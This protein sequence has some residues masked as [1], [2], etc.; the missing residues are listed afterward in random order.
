MAAVDELTELV[1]RAAAEKPALAS[2]NGSGVPGRRFGPT[3]P[4][5]RSAWQGWP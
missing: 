2:K 1:E 4:T 5:P 3:V